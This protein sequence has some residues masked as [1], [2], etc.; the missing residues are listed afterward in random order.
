MIRIRMSLLTLLVL[1]SLPALMGSPAHARLSAKD[2]PPLTIGAIFAAHPPSLAGYDRNNIRTIIATGDVIPARSVNYK[3][4][5]YG[6]FVYPFRR[7]GAF[8]RTG[9]ITVVNLESPLIAGCPVTNE[10]M[11]FCGDPRA[12]QGLTYAGVDVATI[13]NEHI[14][15]EGQAGIDE[16]IRYLSAAGIAHA[17]LG[18]MAIKTVRGIRFGFLAYNTI[19]QRFDYGQAQREIAAARK[20]ADVLIVAV[21]W[22]AEYQLVPTTA[23]G[24]AD[25]DPRTVGH[26]LIDHG[27]DLVLGNHPHQV[28]GVEIYHHK[29]IA[30]AHGNFVFD[31]MWSLET[32]QGVVG[33]YRFYGR[34]LV[35][36]QYKPVIIDD[37]SQPHWARPAEGIPVINEMIAS[38]LAIEKTR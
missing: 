3:M 24:I 10:G 37:Y 34:R 7:V 25:D 21:H 32:R 20:Q 38:T 11:S 19:G 12:V 29:L 36:V 27:V 15:N 28:Q 17:G 13:G 5:V 31:Q 33:V 30:Y 23:P 6:D 9:D 35:A 2:P 22:G 18:D 4:T 14:H 1:T 8:L 16:T 26:W